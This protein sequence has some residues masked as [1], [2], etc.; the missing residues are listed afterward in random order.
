MTKKHASL[1]EWRVAFDAR[2]GAGAAAEFERMLT[3][4]STAFQ[5]IAD[6]FGFSR[7]RVSQLVQAHFPAR[8]RKKP[9]LRSQRARE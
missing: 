5:K 4:S 7:Q 3:S 2:H 6:R 1:D 9:R 8:S